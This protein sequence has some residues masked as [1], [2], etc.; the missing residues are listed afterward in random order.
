MTGV[1]CFAVQGSGIVE[2]LS[3]AGSLN[4]LSL[5]LPQ[6]VYTTF[7]TY[8]NK[9]VLRLDAHLGR[10]VDSAS[11]E[12]HSLDLDKNA[13]R[14]AIAAALAESGYALARVRL[15]VGFLPS[16]TIFVS[17]DELH[18]LPLEV[19]EQGVSAQIAERSL[20]REA[21]RSKSTRFIGPA[22]SARE[23]TTGANEVL[24]VDEQQN[25]LEGSSSNF[26]A[27]LDGVLRTADSGALA[28]VTRGIVLGSA[29][30][31]VPVE[32]SPVRV[33]DLP[34]L[35]EA[36]VTSV[37]RAVLPVVEID[38]RPVGDG[39]P[40]EITRELMR[41]FEAA[42]QREL[43]PIVPGPSVPR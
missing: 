36:F 14:E 11:I 20:R 26:F 40:G 12:G 9:M 28:G 30:G 43:E 38:A 4:E 42:L 7:R 31:V 23:A 6:G 1:R 22:A 41:Q 15:T 32:L 27:V 21:P 8:A 29:Q 10:L 19:Y 35:Q 3:D 16:T 5:S 24:L 39:R 34:L 25:I 33:A 2:V 13:I 37:S 18:E 17:L